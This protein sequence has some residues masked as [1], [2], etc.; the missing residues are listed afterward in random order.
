MNIKNINIK[1]Y[2]NCDSIKD[3]WIAFQDVS[4]SF[5]F[6][7]YEWVSTWY[8]TI[9]LDRKSKIQI[10]KVSLRDEIIMILPLCIEGKFGGKILTFSDG[11]YRCGL[12]CLNFDTK[13]NSEVF[14]FIW[15]A[16]LRKINNYDFTIDH[17]GYEI[18][19]DFVVGYGLD[20][21]QSYRNLDGIYILD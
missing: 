12:F 7:T 2:D 21:N 20:F 4:H 8:S 13:I 17:I 15:H 3:E 6:Q 1:I 16:I 18:G 19:Q 11:D 9:G 14:Y 5:S 10:V